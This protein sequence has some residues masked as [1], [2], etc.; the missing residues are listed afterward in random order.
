MTTQQELDEQLRRSPLTDEQRA[1]AAALRE[2][3]AVLAARNVV[4][5]T[6]NQPEPNDLHALA[7]F[8]LDGGNPWLPDM[9]EKIAVT[10]QVVYEE[11]T[12]DNIVRA[13]LEDV[14]ERFRENPNTM[15]PSVRRLRRIID[16]VKPSSPAQRGRQVV[17]DLKAWRRQNGL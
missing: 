17:Q 11:Q 10:T 5:Q 1:R 12:V 4:G 7:V 15:P 9:G 3:R 14:F 8:I 2:A 6:L 13:A 16:E